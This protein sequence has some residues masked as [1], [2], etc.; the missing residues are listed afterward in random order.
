MRGA[1]EQSREEAARKHDAFLEVQLRELASHGQH[2]AALYSQ[3]IDALS[4]GSRMAALWDHARLTPSPSL[5]AAPDALLE[6]AQQSLRRASMSQKSGLEGAAASMARGPTGCPEVHWDARKQLN[7]VKR[8][9]QRQ[10]KG[11]AARL[12][13]E[14]HNAVA[15][16]QVAAQ[17]RRH[18]ALSKCRV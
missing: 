15:A 16:H 14:A 5:D 17:I 4:D 11:D 13:E 8:W 9:A 12:R 6:L 3:A 10:D 2:L 18:N 1:F 7:T